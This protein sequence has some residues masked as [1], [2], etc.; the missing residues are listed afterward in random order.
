MKQ[1]DWQEVMKQEDFFLFTGAKKEKKKK[2][3]RDSMTQQKNDAKNHGVLHH[4]SK[5]GHFTSAQCTVNPQPI[6]SQSEAELRRTFPENT[7][8]NHCFFNMLPQNV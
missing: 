8:K 5:I 6:H 3:Y 2:F 7:V 4:F 1:S